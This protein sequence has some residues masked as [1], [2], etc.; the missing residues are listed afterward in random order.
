MKLEVAIVLPWLVLSSI[1]SACAVEALSPNGEA[2][3]RLGAQGECRNPP[4]NRSFIATKNACTVVEQI[5]V[6]DTCS[7]T[8]LVEIESYIHS[9]A[10]SWLIDSNT[11]N[12]SVVFVVQ[13]RVVNLK[14]TAS[15]EN[16]TTTSELTDWL[17]MEEEPTSEEPN[18]KCQEAVNWLD[19]ND[20]IKRH[21][22][23]IRN[24]INDIC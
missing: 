20:E 8:D 2:Q 23:Y 5:A 16:Q 1:Q 3:D 10:I 19:A 14:V 7:D 21:I 13:E 24:Y 11:S 12:I 17:S 6:L 22:G 4:S 9:I 18:S 15:S